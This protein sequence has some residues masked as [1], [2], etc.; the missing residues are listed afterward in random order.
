MKGRKK[1]LICIL[2]GLVFLCGY[3]YYKINNNV[4]RTYLIDKYVLGQ[5][6]KLDNTEIKVKSIKKAQHT[7]SADGDSN[8]S[9]ALEVN[10]KNISKNII[11]FGG[12]TESKLSFGV[13]YRDY[14]DVT[15]D[16]TKIRKLLPQ[17]E[18]NVTLTYDITKN[19]IDYIKN[20]DKVEF[21]I[22]T[23]LYKNEI[24]EKTKKMQLYGK[25]IELGCD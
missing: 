1:Y 17:E 16:I 7:I 5:V 23:G 13:Y 25:I 12:I 10:I 4:A 20:E 15:G 19:D 9:Y 3:R 14:C 6:V 2:I 11:S 8:I 24:V 18:A 21:Y 22:G